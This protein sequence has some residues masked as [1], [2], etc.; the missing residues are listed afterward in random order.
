MNSP[1]NITV[2]NRREDIII[3]NSDYTEQVTIHKGTDLNFLHFS[4]GVI[5][6]VD[7]EV[8]L[9]PSVYTVDEGGEW[10]KWPSGILTVTRK[11]LEC[12]VGHK[13]A[14]TGLPS[15]GLTLKFHALQ[16]GTR[17]WDVRNG[18]RN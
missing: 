18:W 17:I 3:V 14:I 7:E 4:I 15:E 1:V 5:I 8:P 16:I 10:I 9:H 12:E 11:F 13:Y 6:E 2:Q